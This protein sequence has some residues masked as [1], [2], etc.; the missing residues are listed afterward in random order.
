MAC[1]VN[2]LSHEL[3][4]G[5]HSMCRHLGASNVLASCVVPYCSILRAFDGRCL[6]RSL[7]SFVGRGKIL[8]P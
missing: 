2:G 3:K 6:V 7:I 8:T 5:T 1:Y 4:L